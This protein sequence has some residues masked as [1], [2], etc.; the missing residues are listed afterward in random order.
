MC[1][2]FQVVWDLDQI[3]FWE[4]ETNDDVINVFMWKVETKRLSNSIQAQV[5]TSCGIIMYGQKNLPL[6]WAR[7][8]FKNFCCRKNGVY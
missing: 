1:E 3:L 2:Q 4:D 5:V 6:K 7:V 8:R